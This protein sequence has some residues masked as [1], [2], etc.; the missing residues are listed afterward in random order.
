[1]KG[2]K[3]PNGA[4]REAEER[5]EQR[6]APAHGLKDVIEE[7][8]H[9]DIARCG[10]EVGCQTQPATNKEGECSSHYVEQIEDTGN[11]RYD[12]RRRGDAAAIH[13]IISSS[14][15]DSASKF[16]P[17]GYR[18][19]Q[20]TFCNAILLTCR[21]ELFLRIADSVWSHDYSDVKAADNSRLWSR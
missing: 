16:F 18:C 8:R 10:D 1:M 12:T 21:I 11:P 2:A 14:P 19:A 17:T 15:E 13:F 3:S 6:E 5:C 9:N 7:Q 4:P 20:I